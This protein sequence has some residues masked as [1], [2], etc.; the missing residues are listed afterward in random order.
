MDELGSFSRE[1]CGAV[2]AWTTFTSMSKW[3][4]TSVKI[5]PSKLV[6][7]NARAKAEGITR[8][9][10]IMRALDQYMVLGTEPPL[11]P[12]PPQAPSRAAL[13]A[14]VL[15]AAEAKAAHLATPKRPKSRW[16]LKGVH[17]GPVSQPLGSRLKGSPPRKSKG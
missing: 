6:A 4:P 17:L 5:H 2:D 1:A 7:I 15:A 8:H 16:S 10:L 14:Q 12:P 9:A 3:P 13:A 11:D